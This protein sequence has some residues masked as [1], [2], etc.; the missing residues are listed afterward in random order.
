MVATTEDVGPFGG[1]ESKIARDMLCF[2]I[3][4]G[5]GGREGRRC[6]TGGCGLCPRYGRAGLAVECN[7]RSVQRSRTGQQCAAYYWGMQLEN[8][9]CLITVGSRL[10]GV[11]SGGAA[12]L[13][14][15]ATAD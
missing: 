9:R 2:T 10:R 15:N 14:G 13:L 7:G 11:A 5:V 12:L 1:S 8:A 6:R 4:T 3:E